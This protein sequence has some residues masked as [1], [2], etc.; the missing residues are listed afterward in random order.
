MRRLDVERHHREQ[1]R[2]QQRVPRPP[3]HAGLEHQQHG[4][5]AEQRGD[6]AP[7]HV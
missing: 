2:R 6:P 5:G 3:S 4:R 7:P 1:P